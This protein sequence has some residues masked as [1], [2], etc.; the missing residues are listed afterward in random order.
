MALGDLLNGRRKR[1]PNG[2]VYYRMLGPLGLPD[3]ASFERIGNQAT[4]VEVGIVKEHPFKPG[5]G[6]SAYTD[7]VTA[8]VG[9]HRHSQRRPNVSS[10][11]HLKSGDGQRHYRGI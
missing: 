8:I 3:A 6:W 1:P 7:N 10:I 4:A 9:R 2:V 5:H 11:G